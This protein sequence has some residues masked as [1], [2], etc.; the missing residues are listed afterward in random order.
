VL[1]STGNLSLTSVSENA[2]FQRSGAFGDAPTHK[3]IL[4]FFIKK[5]KFKVIFQSFL[6]MGLL[7]GGSPTWVLIGTYTRAGTLP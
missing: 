1:L 4:F 3:A 5:K 7:E 2:Q 6:H